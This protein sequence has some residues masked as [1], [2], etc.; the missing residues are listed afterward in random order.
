MADLDGLS[1]PYS[2]TSLSNIIPCHDIH[3]FRLDAS[4]GRRLSIEESSPF[5]IANYVI[6]NVRHQFCLSGI[7]PSISEKMVRDIADSQELIT[8]LFNA[9]ADLRLA[10]VS[11]EERIVIIFDVIS[12]HKRSG[13][14]RALQKDRSY[15]CEL[16]KQSFMPL[17]D[18]ACLLRRSTT[19]DNLNNLVKEKG[20][21]K[22]KTRCSI[23]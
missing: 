21:E 11:L 1:L 20:K 5:E 23:M 9:L 2:D 14:I 19:N 8:S 7:A 22:S 10:N 18:K 17:Y 15:H 16:D 6:D 13:P 12:R 3:K 4:R